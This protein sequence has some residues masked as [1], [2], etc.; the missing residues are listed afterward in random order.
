MRRHGTKFS[1]PGD[2]ASGICAPLVYT[3]EVKELGVFNKVLPKLTGHDYMK[4][5]KYCV[6]V[7]F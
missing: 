7:T 6:Y 5:G 2:L 1:R 4:S 3:H